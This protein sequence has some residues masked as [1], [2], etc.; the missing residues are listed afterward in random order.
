MQPSLRAP[1]R[2]T[3]VLSQL[4][5]PVA[6]FAPA[7]SRAAEPSSPISL[8]ADA[9]LKILVVDDNFDVAQ[10]VGWMIETIGHEY[11]LVHGGKLAVQTARE[12]RPDAILLDIN[13]PGMGGY[14]VCRALRGQ[15]LFNDTVITAQ[16]GMGQTQARTDAEESGFDH[17]LVKPVNM[18]RLEQLLAG[19]LSVQPA[20]D[21]GALSCALSVLLT[22]LSITTCGSIPRAFRRSSAEKRNTRSRPLALP[23]SKR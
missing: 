11:R 19:I 15:T 18:D 13:M 22:I 3:A 12:Y 23:P 4:R 8:Q 21:G 17:H 10:T 20:P 16:T 1:G 7:P 14:A 6:V 5:L 2:A 9:A